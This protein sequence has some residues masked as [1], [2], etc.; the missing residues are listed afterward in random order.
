MSDINRVFVSDVG[1][2]ASLLCRVSDINR[3]SLCVV[4]RTEVCRIASQTVFL[5]RMLDINRV[6]VSDVRYKLAFCVEIGT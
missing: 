2:K 6:F 5:C 3:L 1:R 4:R